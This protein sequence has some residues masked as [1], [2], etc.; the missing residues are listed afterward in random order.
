MTDIAPN[1]AYRSIAARIDAVGRR[2]RVGMFLRGAILWIA[3]GAAV[4]VGA[5]LAGHLLRQGTG[6]EIVAGVWGAWMV[7]SAG[8]WIVRPMLAHP[9]R[10]LIARLIEQRVPGLYNGLTNSVLLAQSR[11]LQS[12]PFLPGIFSEVL[13]NIDQKPLRQ[14]V[15]WGDLRAA[16]TKSVIVVIAAG[17]VALAFGGQISHGLRQLLAPQRFVPQTGAVEILEVQPGNVTLLAGQSLEINFTAR[18]PESERPQARLIFQ[19]DF[20]P[21]PLPP[22]V[23]DDGTL[24]YMF[25]ADH[26]DQSTRYRIEIGSTQSDWYSVNVVPQVKLLGTYLHVTPPAYTRQASTNLQG[27]GP[28]TV[29]QGST[30]DF[31]IDFDPAAG[32]AMMGSQEMRMSNSGRHAEQSAVVL[33]DTLLSVDLFQGS[34]ILARLPDPA[35][36]I[37][38]QIDQP[39]TISLIWP[40]RAEMVL[41]PTRD[42]TVEAQLGDDWGLKAA[43]VLI[44]V[45]DGPLAPA[46]EVPAGDFSDQPASYHLRLPIHLNGDEQN[47]R[48]QIEAAD[49]RDI[50]DVGGPQISQSSIVRITFADPQRIAAEARDRADRL[51]DILLRMRQ[52]QQDLLNQAAL[53]QPGQVDSISGI[54]SAQIALRSLMLNTADQFDFDSDTEVVRRAL[55]MLAVNP[56][57]QAVDFSEAIASEPIAGE[58]SRLAALLI[59]Q[60]RVIVTTLD[61]LLAMLSPE[62]PA[63]TQMANGNAPLVS[64]PEAYRRLNDALKKYL[65]AQ[66][67]VVDQTAS[68][69]KI[70]VDQYDL[71]QQKQ[72]ANLQMAQD[73]LDAF[74]HQAFSDF[75]S[76]GQQDLAHSHMVKD[77]APIQAQITAA[78]DAMKT[79]DLQSAIPLEMSAMEMGK[80]IS[81]LLD[82]W[83]SDRPDRQHYSA[84]DPLAAADL[85]AAPLPKE[86]Q[87][88]MGKLLADQQDLFNQMQDANANWRDAT[89]NGAEHKAEDGPIADSSAVGITGNTL[90]KNNEQQG[91]SAE[92]RNGK[93]QGEFVGDSA[94]G[95]GGR[96]TPTRLDQTPFQKGQVNDTSPQSA[97]GATG[98]GKLAG[99]GAQG[100]EGPV[101]QLPPALL[102]QLQRLTQKQDDLRN[103]A[104]RINIKDNAVRYDNFNLQHSILLMGQIESD[105]KANRYDNALALRDELLDDLQ[106]SRLLLGSQISVQEDATPRP[107]DKMQ[108]E[109]DDV[110]RGALPPA[111]AQP[112]TDYYRD[113]SQQ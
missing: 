34:Q 64:K 55:Q 43:R 24:Q 3:C 113:L 42:L 18:A 60:Q 97:S 100:L 16:A 83:L 44:G 68:L 111:W 19:R 7:F 93:A 52:T 108:Q 96:N 33:A 40:D 41:P 30:L 39:P 31:G 63:A 90:P 95:K 74:T 20:A 99:Q 78:K 47:I 85:P 87:D 38:A 58:Q 98:G 28:F 11:D 29:P 45:G 48:L 21:P 35:V 70:P 81:D 10:L 89:A 5:M 84:E 77:L 72:L 59:G 1:A 13:R 103:T 54:H 76:L 88:V 101:P 104:Q 80:Q 73:K 82:K 92:G 69:A 65:D 14:A 46:A 71:D 109:I 25:A 110:M 53:F 27:A 57:K 75:S 6:A 9:N 105:L 2:Y 56:A 8:I 79:P 49:D 112:L 32:R 62:G 102:D 12:S 4:S 61:S 22:H 26:V 66:R 91:R 51:H 106:T 86:L 36:M 15:G 107:L 37:H 17:M 23:R 94:Q 67:K 50:P